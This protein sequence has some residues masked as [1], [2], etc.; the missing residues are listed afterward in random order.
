MSRRGPLPESLRGVPFSVEDARELGVQPG[1]LRAGDLGVP[2]RGVRILAAS[3]G[4]T[5]ELC[6]AYLPVM[7]HG[8]LFSHLTAARLYGIPLPRRLE[9]GDELDVWAGYIQ[10]KS[11]GVIGHRSARLPSRLVDGLPVVDPAHVFVQLATSLGRDDLIV[12]GDFLVRRKSPLSTLDE[13]VDV[14]RRSKG[15]RGI[16][17]L[18][19]ALAD[20]RPGTDSPM[21]TRLRL[22]LIRAGL[23]EPVI[24]HTITDSAGGFVGTPDLCYVAERIAIEYEGDV[25][26]TDS[27]VFAE[28]IERREL[29][30]EEDWY[31]I[32]V[33]ADHVSRHPAWLVDRV[34][35]QL[36]LRS[37]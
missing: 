26:R 35:R 25:H 18:R 37:P 21:E 27:R 23:P 20:V 34:R 4:S 2:F 9:Q 33:I 10:A 7:Q 17:Q 6:N 28:D 12:V 5:V 24:G 1:R 8:Q 15:V 16:R 31:V 19:L 11:A 29:M 13:L 3:P 36:R 14:V 30:Q 32:R 22:V